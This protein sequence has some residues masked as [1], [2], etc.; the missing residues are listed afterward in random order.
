MARSLTYEEKGKDPL[1]KTEPQRTG[2]VRVPDV[3][4]TELIRKHELTLIGRTTNPRLQRIWSLIPFLSDLWKTRVRPIGSDLGQGVFQF[5]FESQEDLQ[6]VFDNRPYH[7]ARWMLILQKWEP[8]VDPTFPSLIPFWI[9]VQGVPLH[10]WSEALL[11]NIGKDQGVYETCEILPGSYRV[12]THIN[13]LLP[14]I[15]HYTLELYSG[16]EIT[17]NLVYEK[18]EKHCC[19]CLILDHDEDKDCP[20]ASKE[21]EENNQEDKRKGTLSEPPQ[22]THDNRIAVRYDEETRAGS[23]RNNKDQSSHYNNSTS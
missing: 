23:Q 7:F 6:Q 11:E 21:R 4:T 9:K 8:S 16:E 12:R 1:E 20:I 5:Q 19:R 18:L 13:G 22:R 3:D 14:L 10:L 17:A 2:R 15:K